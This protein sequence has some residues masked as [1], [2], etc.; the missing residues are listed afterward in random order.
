MSVS[1]PSLVCAGDSVTT[2]MTI[3]DPDGGSFQFGVFTFGPVAPG[4]GC[5]TSSHN[6][7]SNC[8]RI[9][10]RYHGGGLGNPIV[11]SDGFTTT[12]RGYY[13][14]VWEEEECD[15]CGWDESASAQIRAIDCPVSAWWQVKDADITT[16]GNISS[17]IPSGCTLPGCN[18]VFGLDGLGGFPGVVAYGGDSFSFSGTM[19]SGANQVSSKNWLANASYLGKTYGYVYFSKL[20]PKVDC[21]D[22]ATKLCF[23]LLLLPSINGG[24]L[25]SG[26]APHR[27]YVW[28]KRGGFGN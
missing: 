25:N 2:T 5:Q 22:D 26:G 3:R 27:G 14:V 23:N 28:Y 12:I 16:N 10:M 1:A 7:G 4:V 15:S 24:D 21:Q 19:S 18:P 11:R 6:G 9:A 20:G 13:S 17:K 8:T